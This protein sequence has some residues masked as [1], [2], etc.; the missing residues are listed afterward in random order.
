MK[1]KKSIIRNKKGAAALTANV[2]LVATILTLGFLV[3]Y[4][5]SST[6]QGLNNDYVNTTNENLEGIKGPGISPNW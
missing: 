1:D 3:T 4:W 6:A 2:I 5:A